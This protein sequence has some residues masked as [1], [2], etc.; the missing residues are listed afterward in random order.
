[1]SVEMAIR[2]AYYDRGYSLAAIDPEEDARL[3]AEAKQVESLCG[4][5][6]IDSELGMPQRF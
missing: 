2:Q 6:A 4:R 1:M 5:R 3:A